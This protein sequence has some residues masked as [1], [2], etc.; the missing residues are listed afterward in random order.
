MAVYSAIEFK[1]YHQRSRLMFTGFWGLLALSSVTGVKVL[2]MPAGILLLAGLYY[3]FIV[4][5]GLQKEAKDLLKDLGV[6]EEELEKHEIEYEE[7]QK[8][9]GLEEHERARKIEA[10]DVAR[11]DFVTT[12]VTGFTDI[13]FTNTEERIYRTETGNFLRISR[14]EMRASVQMTFRPERAESD[15]IDVIQMAFRI[16]DS[17]GSIW[18]CSQYLMPDLM[19][20]PL[21]AEAENPPRLFHWRDAPPSWKTAIKEKCLIANVLNLMDT[22]DTSE[23]AIGDANYEIYFKY[24]GPRIDVAYLEPNGCFLIRISEIYHE[25]DDDYV[26]VPPLCFEMPAEK[27]LFLSSPH[28]YYSIYD[29]W[30]SLDEGGLKSP[31]LFSCLPE[32]GCA[33]AGVL[34]VE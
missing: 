25:K 2:I 29:E 6:T 19:T 23:L 34:L 1:K 27:F 33:Q 7:E 18:Q 28:C 15:E 13:T 22:R 12:A 32:S 31:I 26:E 3:R 20:S 16:A 9:L 10:E 21:E 11:A 8:R 14:G 17:R 4:K 24:Q 30:V 5:D